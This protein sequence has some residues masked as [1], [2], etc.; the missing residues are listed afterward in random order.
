MD[1]ASIV[2]MAVG[3]T[4]VIGFLSIWVKMGIERGESKKTMENFA[5]RIEKNEAAI[6]ELK[7]TTHNI[8][9]E[10][11]R[12]IGKIEAKLDYIKESVTALK[13]GRRAEE[14]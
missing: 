6:S 9:L 4:A 11:A 8:Q 10:I 5:Q 13:G 7:N 1:M 14:K 2:G 3:A 12:S